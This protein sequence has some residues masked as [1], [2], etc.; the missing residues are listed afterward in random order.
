MQTSRRSSR[1]T[2][3][4]IVALACLFKNDSPCVPAPA[5]I[6]QWNWGSPTAKALARAPIAPWLR[7]RVLQRHRQ[8]V[9]DGQPS[10][11]GVA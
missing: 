9:A 6:F 8:V 11:S 5:R 7:A 10:L 1:P 3:S 4:T 2:G